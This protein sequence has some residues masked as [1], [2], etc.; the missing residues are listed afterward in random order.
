VWHLGLDEGVQLPNIVCGV[1]NRLLAD[2][3]L[4]H[5]RGEVEHAHVAVWL[6]DALALDNELHG[7]VLGTVLKD[8]ADLLRLAL[9]TVHSARAGYRSRPRR[10]ELN[11]QCNIVVGRGETLTGIH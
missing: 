8:A 7:V 4:A 1:C 2:I 9:L 11:K 6:V 5:F 3:F 10:V